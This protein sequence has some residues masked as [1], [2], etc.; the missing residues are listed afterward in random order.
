MLAPWC[1]GETAPEPVVRLGQE[2]IDWW[3]KR[4]DCVQRQGTLVLTHRRDLGELR[5]FSRRTTCHALIDETQINSLEPDLAGRF[6]QGLFFANEG[7]LEPRKALKKLAQNLVDAGVSFKL[8]TSVEPAN[9]NA[10]LI[11][12]CRGFSARK[13]L[14]D[15]RAVKGEMMLIRS[16]DVNI[17]RPIRLLH[18][19]IPL[20]IVPRGNGIY[21]VGA[22][23]L[24]SDAVSAITVRSTLE[25]LNAAFALHPGFGEAEILETGVDARPSYPD[26]LPRLRRDGKVI[27]VNGLHRHGFLLSPVLARMVVESIQNPNEV[28]ELMEINQ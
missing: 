15:L 5:H 3:D 4:V 13:D 24:E 8:G 26:N 6:M 11:I 10:D 1:E 2:A 17:S 9:I 27:H 20:Y 22:T 23:M 25:L 19:R 12:D 14:P 21:M 18:P 7:H 28:P 16:A